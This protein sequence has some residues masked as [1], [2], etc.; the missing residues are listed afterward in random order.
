MSSI[1]SV[2]AIV[3]TRDPKD[4]V[5]TVESLNNQTLQPKKIIVVSGTRKWSQST[6][7][8][9][10]VLM[11]KALKDV[12]LD[13]YDWLLKSD[14]DIF[15]PPDFLEV[16]TNTDYDLMGRGAGILIKTKPFQEHMGKWNESD[17]EDSY[18]YY[19]FESKGLRTLISKWVKPAIL[20]KPAGS[21]LRRRFEAGR[22]AY[23][24]GTPTDIYIY[25]RI[26][27]LRWTKI[28]G[29]LYGRFRKLPKF[30]IAP[31]WKAYVRLRRG[32]TLPVALAKYCKNKKMRKRISYKI[33]HGVPRWV[34][35]PTTLQLD[36][37]NYCNM[38][39]I[40]CNPQGSFEIEHGTMS[41]DMI[42]YILSYFYDRKIN[43]DV[44]AP[45]MNG[46]VLLEKRLPVICALSKKYQPKA[47][48]E[49]YTNGVAY[50]NRDLLVDENID[51]VRF[52]ISALTRDK[53]K[54]M[55]GKDALPIVLKTLKYVTENKYPNQKIILNYVLTGY[56]V[57]QLSD[58]RK[59]F[60]D[61]IQ[62]IRP[63]HIGLHRKTSKN[64]DD[65]MSL[66]W[67]DTLRLTKKMPLIAGRHSENRPCPCWHNLSITWDGN[68]LQCPDTSPKEATIGKI[69]EDDL[70]TVWRHRFKTGKNNPICMACNQRMPHWD[71]IF[72]RYNNPS[73]KTRMKELIISSY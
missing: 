47:R 8:I 70:L 24:V 28:I 33:R 26:F 40:Y 67:A 25:D 29:F 69:G 34:D 20:M 61:Y 17:M 55:H 73:L 54:L 72:R 31:E 43:V 18:P 56:N 42:E 10:G 68:I 59:E 1:Q 27:K 57:D 66:S 45:F 7:H 16:N 21:S 19:V 51:V 9:V 41:L 65:K 14:D 5:E 46:D 3:V 49:A 2:L 39:C 32:L 63:L 53:Y 38:E 30:S 22:D 62:D 11:N 12:N 64:L 44:V 58:W 50:E 4:C 13:N 52:T 37:H 35:H 71:N 60:S 6:G 15:Y 23:R 36:T 48:I